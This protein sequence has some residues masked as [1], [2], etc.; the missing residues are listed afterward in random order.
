MS[1]YATTYC[2]HGYYVSTRQLGRDLVE[3]EQLA[4]W[5]GRRCVSAA[6]QLV[7]ELSAIFGTPRP[8]P[9]LVHARNVT[10]RVAREYLRRRGLGKLVPYL[11]TVPKVR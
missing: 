3:Y 10:P 8:S 1:A 5:Q 4:T 7:L 2:G 11:P 6:K 9:R